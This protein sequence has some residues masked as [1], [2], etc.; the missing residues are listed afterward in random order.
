MSNAT[1]FTM[2]TCSMSDALLSAEWLLTSTV[3]A[4]SKYSKAQKVRVGRDPS[5]S[6]THSLTHSLILYSFLSTLA[7]ML[8]E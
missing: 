8:T 2:A 1:L 6:L 3:S 5:H 7:Y 4:R